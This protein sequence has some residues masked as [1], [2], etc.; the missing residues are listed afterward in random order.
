[1]TRRAASAGFGLDG[2]LLAALLLGAGA[3]GA[4]PGPQTVRSQSGQFVVRGLPLGAMSSVGPTSSVNYL[5]LD[6]NMTAVSLE[7]IRQAVNTELGLPAGWRGVVQVTT[8]PVRGE[9]QPVRVTSVLFT[10]G[11]GYRMEFPEIVDKPRF[12][13][14]AVEVLLL[15]FARRRA[16]AGEVDLP[17]WLSEGLAAELEHTSLGTLALE[18]FTR[19]SAR[20]RSA[21]PLRAARELLRR[22][23]ALT[24]NELGLPG[25]E[26][27]G[28]DQAAV[29]RASAQLFVHEILHA[30]GGRDRLREFIA[31]LPDHLNWQT[32]F[33]LVF[34]AEFP[35]LIDAEK[36]WALTVV[37]FTG[38]DPDSVGPAVVTLGQLEETL[39]AHV[40]VRLQENELPLHTQVKLQRVISE[41]DWERQAGLLRQKQQQLESLRLRAAPGLAPL[42]GDYAAALREYLQRREAARAPGT[43]A[44]AS[45]RLIRR[46][47]V[48]RLDR[49]DA[50]L[51]DARRRLE[52]LAQ[53]TG[54]GR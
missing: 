29:F 49:L 22:E 50:R 23:P 12:I 26:H 28:G 14:A 18:P 11:W 46:D 36:W 31:R 42:V 34:A 1:V 39:P 6:P 20:Q 37:R 48:R 24:F 44:S 10:D 7:R 8:R 21:D 17:A 9:D 35:R 54:S 53:E 19:V 40:E 30:R 47:A 52:V 51:E 16:G 15:E 38:R 45:L 43:D 4:P 3:A 13:Q 33:L 41:W 2:L 25:P 27:L 5:Q 32:A